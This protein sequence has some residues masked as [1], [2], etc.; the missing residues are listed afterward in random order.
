MR[1]GFPIYVIERGFPKWYP[2]EQGLR[3][4]AAVHQVQDLDG[5]V[6][7]STDRDITMRYSDG[8][9]SCEDMSWGNSHHDHAHTAWSYSSMRRQPL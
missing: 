2:P 7:L 1:L 5:P 6:F 3:P 4:G 9:I 8:F